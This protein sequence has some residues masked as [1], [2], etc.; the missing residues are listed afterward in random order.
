SAIV[1]AA[2]AWYLGRIAPLVQP[3]RERAEAF[4]GIR[5]RLDDTSEVV[6]RLADGLLEEGEEQ[7]ILA[8][9]VLVEPAQRLL[10]PVDDLLDRELGRPLIVDELERRVEEALDALLGPRACRVQAARDRPLPPGR[11]VGV[12]DLDLRHLS[13]PPCRHGRPSSRSARL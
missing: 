2:L 9:E 3:D 6:G 4:G 8:V 1:R 13:Y 10:R 5:R 11:F 7:L 12:G